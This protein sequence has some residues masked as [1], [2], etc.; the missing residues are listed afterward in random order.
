MEVLY[1]GIK[2]RYAYDFPLCSPHELL[3]SLRILCNISAIATTLSLP[4]PVLQRIIIFKVLFNFSAFAMEVTP[5]E[6]SGLNKMCS[7]VHVLLV[8]NMS[9]TAKAPTSPHMLVLMKR[10]CNAEP[11]LSPSSLLQAVMSLDEVSWVRAAVIAR[12]AESF[13]GA[14]GNLCAVLSESFVNKDML[15]LQSSFLYIIQRYS[16]NS[17]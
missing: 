11:R 5:L 10:V 14:W 12:A 1:H 8:R 3:M 13:C 9:A 7:S 16:E 2:T 6:L 15:L 4:H 17:L